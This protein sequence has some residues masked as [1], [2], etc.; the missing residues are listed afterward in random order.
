MTYPHNLFSIKSR[1]NESKE[2]APYTLNEYS[3]NFGI[4][5]ESIIQREGTEEGELF[6]PTENA[7]G[8]YRRENKLDIPGDMLTEN[9]KWVYRFFVCGKDR[10]GGVYHVKPT[11][12]MADHQRPDIDILDFTHKCRYAVEL[13]STYGAIENEYNHI[14]SSVEKFSSV[15][16][17]KMWWDTSHLDEKKR[18]IKCTIYFDDTVDTRECLAVKHFLEYMVESSCVKPR[19]RMIPDQI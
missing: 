15:I 10:Q 11:K 8:T 5:S 4:P 16:A 2:T 3:L 14:M 12:P 9:G 17:Y 1:L 6:R 7:L 18:Q 19:P 13:T